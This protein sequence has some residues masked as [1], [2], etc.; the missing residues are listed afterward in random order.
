MMKEADLQPPD[1]DRKTRRPLKSTDPS[2]VSSSRGTSTSETSA[3]EAPAIAT[4]AGEIP[5]GEGKKTRVFRVR[6]FL[7]I[8]LFGG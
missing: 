3:A 8:K 7:Q 2:T 5:P 6:L 4:A 1:L